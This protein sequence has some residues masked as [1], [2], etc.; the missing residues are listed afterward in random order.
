MA[1]FKARQVAR[2]RDGVAAGRAAVR[3]SGCAEPLV[4]ARAY[5]EA[6][7]PQVPGDPSVAASE[8][9]GQ[10][11][12]A[13][14]SASDAPPA[15]DAELAREVS[16]C[17]S[18][19]QWALT[20]DDDRIVGFLLDLPEAALENPTVEALAHQSQGL[21]PGVFRK[22]DIL[23][24]QPECDGARFIPITHHDVEC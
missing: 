19:T 15:D 21:G 23:V 12:L 8:S 24:L 14:L 22:A 17:V 10:R 4:F 11:L 6:G 13:W 9:L 1:V 5:V 18:E 3:Q 2:I 16:R 7:G 20:L